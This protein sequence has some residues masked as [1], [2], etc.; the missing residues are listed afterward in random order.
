MA[1]AYEVFETALRRGAMLGHEARVVRGAV[2]G[3]LEVAGGLERVWY[4]LAGGGAGTER[5]TR[6]ETVRHGANRET[7]DK[8]G[9]DEDISGG[10]ISAISERAI[11]IKIPDDDA[12]L[13]EPDPLAKIEQLTADF[14]RHSSFA[15][16]GLRSIA[17]AAG[18]GACGFGVFASV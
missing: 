16:A 5:S 4:R 6:A 18:E 10:D 2:L 17:R 14:E 7:D 8:Q 9:V 3:A 13:G 12:G 1:R 15:M 11:T